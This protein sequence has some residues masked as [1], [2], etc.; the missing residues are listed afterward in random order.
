[1]NNS[2]FRFYT[3]NYESD[4]CCM[5]F[6][7]SMP[8]HHETY[9]WKCI[10]NDGCYHMFSC[11]VSDIEAVELV[12]NLKDGI[13]LNLGKVK[14]LVKVNYSLDR[15]YS[16]TDKK[17]MV[18]NK[19]T[20]AFE[21][22]C[23][24]YMTLLNQ[25]ELV[26][27]DHL[28]AIRK[29]EIM[30]W[31]KKKL[32]FSLKEHPK[33]LGAYQQYEKP[34]RPFI[35][36]EHTKFLL[37]LKKMITDDR[38][39]SITLDIKIDSNQLHLCKIMEHGC[40]EIVFHNQYLSNYMR[41]SVYEM[42]SGRM[43]Y[44]DEIYAF[45]K[46][47]SFQ[48]DILGERIVYPGGRL[49]KIKSMAD[50]E[51]RKYLNQN[52]ETLQKKSH[53]SFYV[54]EDRNDEKGI[55]LVDEF[56]QDEP[57]RLCEYI[58]KT[59][60]EDL[61]EVYKETMR[62]IDQKE[63]DE[64]Y[65]I[66]PFFSIDIAQTYLPILEHDHSQ[67][68]IFTCKMDPNKEEQNEDNQNKKNLNEKLMELRGIL[69]VIGINVNIDIINFSQKSNEEHNLL[70]DRYVIHK[71]NNNR[72][73]GYMFSNSLD[74]FNNNYPLTIAELDEVVTVHNLRHVEKLKSSGEIV[75]HYECKAKKKKEFNEEDL[76]KWGQ[77]FLETLKGKQKLTLVEIDYGL[78][79]IQEHWEQDK[80]S[81][82]YVLRVLATDTSEQSE[83]LSERMNLFKDNL[84][85]D[86]ISS[87]YHY[88]EDFYS[89]SGITSKRDYASS[90]INSL[91]QSLKKVY[92]FDGNFLVFP[93]MLLL[94]RIDAKRYLTQYR[95]TRRDEY[96]LMIGH[97]AC[98]K[99]DDFYIQ[100]LYE[101][102]DEVS[103]K[104][105]ACIF[106][107]KFSSRKLTSKYIIQ[108][109]NELD[110]PHKKAC[111]QA[112]L[113]CLIEGDIYLFEIQ[114]PPK[115]II[116]AG[117]TL[118]ALVVFRDE[119]LKEVA[120]EINLSNG[121][122]LRDILAFFKETR[123]SVKTRLILRLSEFAGES[124][125][126]MKIV[127]EWY[128]QIMTKVLNNSSY[129]NCGLMNDYLN[130][131]IRLNPKGN[132]S[133]I[134]RLY[135]K[136]IFTLVLEPYSKYCYDSSTECSKFF[137][138]M[139]L[140]KAY[141][142]IYPYDQTTKSKYDKWINQYKSVMMDYKDL[143]YDTISLVNVINKMNFVIEEKHEH[144][145]IFVQQFYAENGSTKL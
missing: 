9:P 48:L 96:I 10:D 89:S 31:F 91:Y 67:I 30:T 127:K 32:S 68:T 111:L 92:F 123:E 94:I 29:K 108:K 46:H 73:R 64:I 122:R 61:T 16:S 58:E 142:M 113:S 81:C 86:I 19:F 71:L 66:D 144:N 40:Q 129:N 107:D 105:L 25:L 26:T 11:V 83:L 41:L 59:D 136:N 116:N 135:D 72:L 100:S 51:Y 22:H 23:G 14:L 131:F 109:I 1:M 42:S 87:L 24:D 49:Q 69:D 93:I 56:K 132:A 141:T 133:E 15:A 13:Q 80:M 140:F 8:T 6:G 101:G 27:N 54:G 60:A 124:S 78:K 138:R 37:K 103:I 20:K 106:Y 118:D 12:K 45:M 134:N 70:H 38:A 125:I 84:K 126:S 34:F 5:L 104:V 114:H 76:P 117:I 43:I 18:F 74:S 102:L 128:Q 85:K 97:Y 17:A 65:I 98:C 2:Y 139:I 112:C 21:Y 99:Y 44:Y 88:I 50:R 33:L 62:I 119:L 110:N 53:N 63:A 115:Q 130:L 82:I 35:V 7:F 90:Q 121:H 47:L 75:F 4:K 137:F 36:T 28:D 79:L 3:Y 95:S 145:A 77:D 143:G 52:F 120:T 39:Y 57:D 55:Q